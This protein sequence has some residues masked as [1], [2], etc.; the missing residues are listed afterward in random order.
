MTKVHQKT[1]SVSVVTFEGSKP[2][3]YDGKQG[4]VR[5]LHRK[6]SQGNPLKVQKVEKRSMKKTDEC[7]RKDQIRTQDCGSESAWIGIR[8]Q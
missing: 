8:V 6:I 2:S 4:T 1:D 3:C 5:I 7:P